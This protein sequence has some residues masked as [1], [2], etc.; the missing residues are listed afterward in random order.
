MMGLYGSIR[1]V[2]NLAFRRALAKSKI[3]ARATMAIVNISHPSQGLEYSHEEYRVN[4]L[5]ILSTV[6]L[7]PPNYLWQKARLT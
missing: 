2:L 4:L 1:L 6:I 5:M 7:A 3:R